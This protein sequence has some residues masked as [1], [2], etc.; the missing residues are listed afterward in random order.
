MKI[1]VEKGVLINVEVDLDA[2]VKEFT[3]PDG[4]IEIANEALSSLSFDLETL[5]IPK[6]VEKIA[7]GAFFS[8]VSMWSKLKTIVVEEGN[9]NYKSETGCLIDINKNV[10]ILGTENATIPNGIEKL[11]FYSF[12]SRENLLEI[13]IPASVKMID[14]QAFACCPNLKKVTV[15]GKDTNLDRLCFI[16]DRAIEEF[17]LP[18]KSDYE[19]NSGCLIK[20]TGNVL[21]LLTDNGKIDRRGLLASV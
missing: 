16:S 15:L 10:V 6:S 3:V 7:E 21:L 8:E 2:E 14:M 9:K 11:G 17:N 5:N 1:V 13:T 18:E 12:R 4:V 19:F 20:K